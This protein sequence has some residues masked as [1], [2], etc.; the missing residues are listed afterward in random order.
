VAGAVVVRIVW[1]FVGP[2]HAR[3]AQFVPR[4]AV[5]VEY[6]RAFVRGQE[7]RHLGHNPLGALMIVFLLILLLAL[8]LFGWL[9]KTDT[10]FGI[11]WVE[12]THVVLADVLLIAVL[13]HVAGALTASVR[14]R[15][16]LV[17]AMVTGR[18]RP[19]TDRISN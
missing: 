16:N 14:H 12:E 4:P 15:E 7:P 18:K 5:A 2:A 17:W 11:A 19:L 6:A 3:F 13:I 9:Q 10:F 8:C 1:G